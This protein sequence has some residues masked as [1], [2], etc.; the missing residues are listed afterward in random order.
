[1]RFRS[2]AGMSSNQYNS[3]TSSVLHSKLFRHWPCIQHACT[4]NLYFPAIGPF[5]RSERVNSGPERELG[6][7]GTVARVRVGSKSKLFD[8]A[9]LQSIMS[10]TCMSYK[11]TYRTDAA[12]AWVYT[13][14]IRPRSCSKCPIRHSLSHDVRLHWSWV[15]LPRVISQVVAGSTCFRIHHVFTC[16][17]P[18]C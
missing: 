8:C 14:S 10:V 11:N 4:T 9:V 7:H 13:L 1:M 15:P 2:S 17:Y 18:N 3:P 12:H 5:W 16:K 6:L